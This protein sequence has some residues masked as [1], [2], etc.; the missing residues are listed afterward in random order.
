[1][2]LIF[3]T[4]P[5]HL[6][7]LKITGGDNSEPIDSFPVEQWHQQNHHQQQLQQQ[8]QQQAASQP[9]QQLVTG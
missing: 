4:F 2:Y 5:G 7:Q 1:M 9:Y 8:Q 3:F 6:N